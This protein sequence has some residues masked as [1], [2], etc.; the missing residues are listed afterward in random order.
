MKAPRTS[1]WN[2]MIRIMQYLKIFE[3]HGILY[4]NG[5]PMIERFTDADYAKFPSEQKIYYW[6]LYIHER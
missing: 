6:I 3:G 1:H 4:K 2:A 5:H